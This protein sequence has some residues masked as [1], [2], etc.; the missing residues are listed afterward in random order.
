MLF[1]FYVELTASDLC[2]SE[3]SQW[4]SKQSQMKPLL[5]IATVGIFVVIDRGP[6]KIEKVDNREFYKPNGNL[7]TFQNQDFKMCQSK[8]FFLIY[9]IKCMP[10][11]KYYITVY[12]LFHYWSFYELIGY[13]ELMSKENENEKRVETIARTEKVYEV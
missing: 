10:N 8:S 12:F 5:L 6:K 3:A 11:M 2:I 4:L 9:R 1:F 7:E 13:Q